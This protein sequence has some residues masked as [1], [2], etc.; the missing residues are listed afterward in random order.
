VDPTSTEA[1]IQNRGPYSAQ[2]TP[3]QPGT[4]S[5]VVESLLLPPSG[6]LLAAGRAIYFNVLRLLLAVVV[7]TGLKDP[8]G[9]L[10][11]RLQLS[12]S[13]AASAAGDTQQAVLL[14]Q[15]VAEV[16]GRQPATH[17]TRC[18]PTVTR[19]Q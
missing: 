12:H 9:V 10:A 5:G 2:Q 3:L 4:L 15:A 14:L 18:T 19:P 16:L 6:H 8:H 17:P 7:P 1:H 13:R 11:R